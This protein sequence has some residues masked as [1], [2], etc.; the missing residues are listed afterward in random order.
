MTGPKLLEIDP[1]HRI[2]A[3]ERA[4][5]S[6]RDALGLDA[7]DRDGGT[8]VVRIDTGAVTSSF[9]RGLVGDSVRKLGLDAFEA[10]YRFDTTPSI[11]ETIHAS[12]RRVLDAP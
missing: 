7:V 1:T 3:G 8:A 2:L 4:G 5:Q 12:A 6:V 9:I 11:R 10:K